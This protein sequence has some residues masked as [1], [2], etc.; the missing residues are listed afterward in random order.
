VLVLCVLVET[1]CFAQSNRHARWRCNENENEL[2][3]DA[4][5]SGA[6]LDHDDSFRWDKIWSLEAP[7]KVKMFL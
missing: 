6:V 1:D 3:S 5:S 2:G 7:N 4:S